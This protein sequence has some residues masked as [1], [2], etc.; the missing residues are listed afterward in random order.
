ME[1]SFEQMY[2]AIIDKDINYEGIF[3]TA[4][5]TT[6]IFLSTFLYCKETQT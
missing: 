6:G 4:V 2:Q 3:F 5:K 1:L